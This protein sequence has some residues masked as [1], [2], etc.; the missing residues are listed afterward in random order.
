MLF[1]ALLTLASQTPEKTAAPTVYVHE[2]PADQYCVS[3][4]RR[5]KLIVIQTSTPGP[6][7]IRVLDR[8]GH[9]TFLQKVKQTSPLHKIDFSRN[10]S[11]WYYVQLQLADGRFCGD[12]VNV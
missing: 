2:K 4:D 5:E 8:E 6:V 3:F 7:R 12:W 10:F 11:G 1:F 9:I